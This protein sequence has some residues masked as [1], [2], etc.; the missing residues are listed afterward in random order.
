M[1]LHFN[2]IFKRDQFY[3][4][5]KSNHNTSQ[6]VAYLVGNLALSPGSIPRSLP[7]LMCGLLSSHVWVLP[8]YMCQF[9][10]LACA[11]A[12]SSHVCGC[13]LLPCV[14]TPSSHVRVSTHPLCECSL[15]TCTG[16]LMVRAPFAGAAG[17]EKKSNYNRVWAREILYAPTESD[18][19]THLKWWTLEPVYSKWVCSTLLVGI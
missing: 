8:P 17:V 14:S 11:S 6:G 1:L 19:H 9:L 15:P 12:P 16:A 18:D 7:P 10:L 4:G 5:H 2:H 13:L 3:S